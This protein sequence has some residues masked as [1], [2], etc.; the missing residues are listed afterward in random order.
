MGHLIAALYELRERLMN[1]AAGVNALAAFFSLAEF[2]YRVLIPS[3]ERTRTA[4]WRCV[5]HARAGSIAVGK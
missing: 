2:L 1:E 4:E 3:D 5:D